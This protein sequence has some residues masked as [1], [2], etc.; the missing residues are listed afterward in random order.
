MEILKVSGYEA[1]RDTVDKL[2]QNRSSQI[3]VY[4]TGEKDET[5]KS[6]CPDCNEGELSVDTF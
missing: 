6:W 2:T 1:F 5:G 4:F 3:N